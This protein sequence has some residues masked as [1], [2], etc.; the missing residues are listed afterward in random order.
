M[1]TKTMRCKTKNNCNIKKKKRQKG[2]KK[3]KI[4]WR[5]YVFFSFPLNDSR[6]LP[7]DEENYPLPVAFFRFSCHQREARANGK[8]AGDSYMLLMI[9]ELWSEFTSQDIIDSPLLC[10]TFCRSAGDAYLSVWSYRVIRVE[11]YKILG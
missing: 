10:S 7:R 9:N 6:V 2:E 8:Q 11:I 3:T 1:Q 4:P 5:N